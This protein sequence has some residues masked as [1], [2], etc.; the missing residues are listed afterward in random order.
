MHAVADTHALV[1]YLLA[2]ARLSARARHA[3]DDAAASGD[4]IGVPSICLIE[5]IY[6]V[7]KGRV[8]SAALDTLVAQLE[9][10]TSVLEMI[11]LDQATALSVR[12]VE[13]A[14]VTD[15]PDRIIAATAL[16]L[17][18][19]LISR[20]RKIRLSGLETIW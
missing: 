3:F 15:M 18:L 19:S 2:D 13:R 4:T 16:R 6:L 7:D 10:R 12:R 9:T 11:P 1:W 14:Q 8:P 20:D 17:R 5:I